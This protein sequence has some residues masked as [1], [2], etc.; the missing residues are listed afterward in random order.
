MFSDSKFSRIFPWIIFM[1]LGLIGS[2][3][4]LRRG[5]SMDNTTV[6]VCSSILTLMMLTVLIILLYNLVKK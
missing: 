2:V 5:V 1:V 4:N 6:I 3:G